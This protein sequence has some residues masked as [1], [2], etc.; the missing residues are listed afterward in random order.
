MSSGNREARWAVG[1]SVRMYRRLLVAY[2]WAFRQRYGAHMVQV[3]RDC[4]RDAGRAAGAGGIYQFWLMVL[5]DLAVS[6]LKERRQEG[7]HMSRT[8]WIRLGSL[9][10]LIGGI[11]GA[12]LAGLDLA[13]ATL[14]LLD[15]NSSLGL[16]LF[17]VQVAATRTT[18]VLWLLFVLALVGLQVRGAGRAGVL[19]WVAITA[20]VLGAVIIELGNGL[21][22]VI[23]YS[24]ADGC[25]TPLNCNY[26]DPNHYLYLDFMAGL[27]GSVIFASGMIIY[28]VAALTRRLLSRH[29]G[30]PLVVGVMA[31]LGDAASVIATSTSSGTDYAGTQ[32]L[33]IMLAVVALATAVVWVL[34]GMAMWPRGDEEAVVRAAV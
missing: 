23:M 29:N 14:Q 10:A 5:S 6:A 21:V 25:R 26:F 24:Q 32:K 3:F 31:L 19:G 20:A 7:V 16:A 17:P 33:A 4:C 18:P 15:E 9:A 13:L 8:F 11:T 30:L 12:L 34:L 28:G 27:L 1:L 2:P 22:A